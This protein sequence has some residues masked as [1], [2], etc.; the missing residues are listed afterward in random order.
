MNVK[1]LLQFLDGT[2]PFAQAEGF[3]NCGLQCGDEEAPVTCVG[4]CLDATTPVLEQAARLGCTT[5]LSHHPLTIEG[6]R[7][8]SLQHPYG[9]RVHWMIQHGITHIAL[10]TNWDKAP[11]GVDDLFAETVGLTSPSPLR[12]GIGRI[13]E[14]EGFESAQQ[15]ARHLAEVLN[16]P[17]RCSDAGKPPRRVACVCGSGKDW[18]EDAVQ[19]GADTFITGDITYHYWLDGAEWGINLID[20]GHFASETE[21]VLEL[22][23]R[24]K[25]AFPDLEIH[26][27]DQDPPF[28]CYP[29]L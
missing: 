21:G 9:R 18:L 15:L 26:L 2:A 19:A 6:Q 16:A 27:L 25:E 28:V 17:V 4:L 14:L 22:A 23:A 20:A 12:D 7:C 24:L 13:G 1:E 5:V 3:D 29:N 8:I 10:H 11:G